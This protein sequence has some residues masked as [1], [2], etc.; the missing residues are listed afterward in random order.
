MISIE[1]FVYFARV[2]LKFRLAYQFNEMCWLL[3]LIR[4]H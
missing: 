4:L 2:A 3:I 1:K